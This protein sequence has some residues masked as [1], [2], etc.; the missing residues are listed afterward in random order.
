MKT[1]HAALLAFAL[2]VAA[3]RQTQAAVLWTENAENGYTYVIDNTGPTY[4][5]SSTRTFERPSPMS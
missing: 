5:L 4:P 3:A 2:A 1:R